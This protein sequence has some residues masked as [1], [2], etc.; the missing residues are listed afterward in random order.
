MFTKLMNRNSSKMNKP[1]DIQSKVS[2][3]SLLTVNFLRGLSEID[4][5]AEAW[6]DPSWRMVPVELLWMWNMY[7]I[8]PTDMAIDL[9]D[10]IIYLREG[11]IRDP[12]IWT[13]SAIRKPKYFHVQVVWYL[14]YMSH[15]Y[16]QDRTIKLCD[17]AR[18]LSYQSFFS[19]GLK[20]V[21]SFVMNLMSHFC[22]YKLGVE[23]NCLRAQVRK[24][25][26]TPSI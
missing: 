17:W 23:P 5:F 15:V 14:C 20:C 22:E 4:N 10:C 13:R 11:Q 24:L 1:D 16:H 9:A 3:L 26:N 12:K 7:D 6:T 8:H 2:Q 25:C 21:N 19:G 18:H